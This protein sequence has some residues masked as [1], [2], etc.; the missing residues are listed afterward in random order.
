MLVASVEHARTRA[1]LRTANGVANDN[2][3]LNLGNNAIFQLN[4]LT[5][6]KDNMSGM[7]NEK[8]QFKSLF[9]ILNKTSTPMG[10]R[11]LKQNLS[12][13]LVSSNQLQI[14]YNF[15]SDLMTNNRWSEIEQRLIG[16]NDIERHTRKISLSIIE[17]K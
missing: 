3:Y 11:L 5:F 12:Q 4:L 8:T 17:T 10:R 13:P 7:Y 1:H 9:D 6:D 16:I 14:R 15:I 2:K